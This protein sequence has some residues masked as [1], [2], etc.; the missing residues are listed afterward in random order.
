MADTTHNISYSE[1]K[2]H[3]H[4]RRRKWI[5]IGSI[6]LLLVIARLVMPY[7]VL[8]YVNKVLAKSESYPGHVEDI[9]LAL[10][11]GAYVIKEI[12]INKRDTIT[13][14]IDTIPF[15]TARALDLSVEW[16]AIFKGSIVGEI[17]VEEPRVN[18]V[19]GKHKD[20]NVKKDT[21]DFKD[22][23]RDLMPLT[24]N[25][26]EVNNGNIHYVDPYSNPALDVSLKN[27]HVVALNLT[28]VNDS[29]SVL[30]ASMKASAEAYDGTMDLNVKF[31]ALEKQPT[32]DLNA[33]VTDVN[34]VKLNDFFKAYGNFDV[35]AG[36]FGLYTEFAA[37]EG[38]FN[39]YVKP[40]IRDLDVVQWN[41]EEGHLGQILWESVI[42]TVGELF[43]NQPRDQ[44][45]TK[46]PIQGKFENPDI[47][48]WNAISYVLRNA[49]VHALQPSVDQTIDLGKVEEVD[50]KKTF[51]QKVFGKDKD[52]SSDKEEE[53]GSKKEQR[54]K[55][56]ERGNE[57]EKEEKGAQGW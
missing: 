36:K 47:N 12:R 57:A 7:F 28:N 21:A 42:G 45:A 17:A 22:V 25:R 26:F 23:I 43:E 52:K 54:K 1:G 6:V 9:D 27:L 35:N 51:L 5:I 56:R 29:N 14:K 38:K 13:G 8:K 31:N 18:F 33:R 3:P 4:K 37:K 50:T 48:M 10:I 16:K 39:G 41:K 34:M 46:V 53:A 44:L 15:F 2:K 24:I 32:F 30:P 55:K 20:E 49:F 40:L 19:K 11:R